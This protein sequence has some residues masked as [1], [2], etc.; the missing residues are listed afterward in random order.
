MGG[1]GAGWRFLG[2]SMSGLWR[3]FV[4]AGLNKK[5][6]SSLLILLT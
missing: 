5:I 1:L 4:E 3:D 6:I 2:G